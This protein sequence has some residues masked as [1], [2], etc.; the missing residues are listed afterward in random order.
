MGRE[1]ERERERVW[2]SFNVKYI[3]ILC[4]Y[5]ENIQQYVPTRNTCSLQLCFHFTNVFRPCAI[6]LFNSSC[7]N[8]VFL[9]R[10][11][12]TL[13]GV[14]ALFIRLELWLLTVTNTLSYCIVALI[15]TVWSFVEKSTGP[16]V[17]KLFRSVINECL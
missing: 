16:N 7:S 8:L 10:Q 17:I 2:E 15:T 13:V 14:L 1:R 3:L 9:Q 11:E 12:P 4:L 5:I 6:K